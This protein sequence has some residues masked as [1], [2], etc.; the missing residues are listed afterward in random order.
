M[1]GHPAGRIAI[2]KLAPSLLLLTLI[3]VEVAANPAYAGG[4]NTSTVGVSPG[5]YDLNLGNDFP[6]FSSVKLSYPDSAILTNSTGDL[7]FS[8]TL[9][10]LMLNPTSAQV[11]SLV[12]IWGSGFS[13][14]DT[15]CT[16]SGT[17]VAA[18]SC[19]IANGILTSGSFVVANVPSGTYTVIATGNPA[20]DHSTT[21]F[22]VLPPLLALNPSSGP[23]GTTVV[24]LTGS[25]FYPSDSPCTLTGT[26]VGPPDHC[27]IDAN[28]HL[29]GTFTVPAGA[30]SASYGVTAAGNTAGDSAGAIFQVSSQQITL[31]PS[32]STFP[33]TTSITVTGSGFSLSDTGCTLSGNIVAP[34]PPTCSIASGGFTTS[35]TE[36]N[37]PAGVYTV[38]ATGTIS[39]IFSDSA[40]ANF[41][42]FPSLSPPEVPIS[43]PVSVNIYIP[44]DFSGLSSSS[45]WTSFTN[46]YD[47]N[48]IRLSRLSASDPIGPNWYEVSINNLTITHSPASYSSPLVAHRIFIINQ[49]Q[50]IRLFQVASPLIAGRYFFKA[51]I[52]GVSIGASNFP[53]LVVKASRDP[54]YISGVL[55]EFGERNFTRAG[56][57][58]TLPNG[59]GARVL[60]AGYDY[61]GQPVSAQAF[62]NSTAGGQYTLF[63]VAPGN[64]QH[65]GVRGGVCSGL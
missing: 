39:G 51:F 54:A 19:T 1:L 12:A 13:L 10:P 11:G 2:K 22:T 5:K 46:N 20:G 57:P 63:G 21:T 41:L 50:Y 60:A 32:Q 38:T 8:V 35:F 30:V 62:I 53:T 24:T 29:S 59:T 28:G 36:A 48:S 43:A 65:N 55:R 44:P 45:I 14:G 47:S 56:Q 58:I 27:S 64:L 31:T 23:A 3:L 33:A 61:L 49:T 4:A 42:V 40:T 25:G 34:S 16:L 17:P 7:L 9:N 15:S 26:P 52:N 37:V 6:T 18:P